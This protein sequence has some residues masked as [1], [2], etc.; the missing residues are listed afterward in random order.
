MVIIYL[1]GEKE[2][3]FE[4]DKLFPPFSRNFGC[5]S[6]DNSEKDYP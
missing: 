6:E 3:R 4:E 2:R 5:F 1:M